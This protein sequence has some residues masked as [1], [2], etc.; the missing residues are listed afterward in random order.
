MTVKVTTDVVTFLT[1]ISKSLLPLGT[2]RRMEKPP[3]GP[4]DGFART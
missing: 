4:P 2:G 3:D 1:P